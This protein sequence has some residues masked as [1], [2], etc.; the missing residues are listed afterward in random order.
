M[1]IKAKVTS[2]I[3]T[4]FSTAWDERDGTVVPETDDVKLKDGAVNLDVTVLYADLWHSTQLQR[5]FSYSTT[6][7][8]VR[9]YL[10]SMAQIVAHCGGHVRS[11]DGDRVMGIFIGDSKNTQAG[12]CA[13]K[14]SR[15][16]NEILRPKAETRFPVLKARGF[17]IRHCA[18]AATSEVLVVRGGVRGHNDLVF[19]GE[20]P[21]IAAKLSELRDGPSSWITAEVHNRLNKSSKLQNGEGADMWRSVTKKIA[22]TSRTLYS[23]SYNRDP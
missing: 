23:S 13:L 18:G 17:E 14:M 9:A 15:T 12:D 1:G 11:F 5:D 8:I 21:N 7:K 6:A 16:V 19:I 2:D 4:I 3:E 20:A 10:S 22:G